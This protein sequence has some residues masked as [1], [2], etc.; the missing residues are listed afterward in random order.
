MRSCLTLFPSGRDGKPTRNIAW[1][2]REQIL[3]RPVG[4][5]LPRRRFPR[6]RIPDYPRN[7]QVGE[8]YFVR[9]RRSLEY[10]PIQSNED[11][12]T[13][14][15]PLEEEIRAALSQYWEASD[16]DDFA[17]DVRRRNFLYAAPLSQ[18]T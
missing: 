7:C 5:F 18:Q 10:R 13:Q 12:E 16:A 11:K 9:R 4:E 1:S 2:L 3:E 17:T 15:L 6:E 8:R 14:A